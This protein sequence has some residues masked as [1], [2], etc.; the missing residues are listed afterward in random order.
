MPV[1]NFNRLQVYCFLM[2]TFEHEP[3]RTNPLIPA[4]LYQLYPHSRLY[5]NDA[6]WQLPD[7]EVQHQCSKIQQH[8]SC[9]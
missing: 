9:L 8:S 5:G 7:A 6:P 2:N 4:G 1:L 3:E